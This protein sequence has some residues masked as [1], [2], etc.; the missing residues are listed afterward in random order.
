[1]DIAMAFKY[2][3]AGDVIVILII[4]GWTWFLYKNF[5]RRMVERISKMVST[6][7]CLA[8]R[9]QCAII[10]NERREHLRDVTTSESAKLADRLNFIQ[11]RFDEKIVNIEN[12]I[13][14]GLEIQ[15][16]NQELLLKMMGK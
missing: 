1:M 5:A 12:K 14:S 11:D 15:K 16:S 13:D 6:E 8:L 4:L 10:V 2:L 7:G 9:N 3:S